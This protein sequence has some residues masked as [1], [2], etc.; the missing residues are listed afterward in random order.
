M[1]SFWPD[2]NA[3]RLRNGERLSASKFSLASS[4]LR[5][6]AKLLLTSTLL[7]TPVL[8]INMPVAHAQVP[9]VTQ[10]NPDAELLLQ[11]DRLIYDND[12]K[13]VTAQ[14]NVQLDYDGYRV[15][16]DQVSYNQTTNKVV[17]SGNVEIVE[18]GGNRI[19]ADQIDLTDDFSEGFVNALRVETTD[20]TRFAAESAERFRDQK[21]VFYH[22]VYTACEACKDKPQKPPL[23]QI[24]AE[25]VILNGVTKTVSYRNARF[26]LFGL[27]I[28]YVPYF[29]HPDGSIKR[30]S[31][32]LTPTVGYEDSVGAWVRQPYF[33]AT[34]DSHDLT[35]AAT[36]FTK[37]GGMLDAKW[38]HQ[39]ENGFY[40]IQVAGIVQQDRTAFS[41][42]PDNAN[43]ERGMI[44]TEGRFTINPKWTFGWK[45]LS[46]TDSNFSRTYKIKNF[47]SYETTNEV[48]LTGLHNR[49]YFNLSA[50]QYLIQNDTLL[51]NGTA[52]QFSSA[53]PIVRPLLDYNY[54]TDDPLAGGQLKL[55]VNVTS[56]ERDTLSF[57]TPSSGDTRTHGIAGDTTRVS[58]DLEWKKSVSAA[59]LNITPLLSLR[60]DWTT[61][62][63]FAASTGTQPTT[64]DYTRFMPTAGLEISYPVLAKVGGSSHIFEPVAQVF[65]R[66]DLDFKGVA[67]NEDAQSL[68]FDATTLFQRD[69]FSGYDRIEGGTRANIGVRYSGQF[70]NGLS[71]D[72]LFG[73]SIHLA[74]LNPYARQDDLTNVGE[75]SGLET[76]RSDFVAALGF[77][78][79]SIYTLNTLGRFDE[80]NFSVR[81]G[82]VQLGVNSELI[83]G[84]SNYTYISAQPDYG[85]E[86][87]RHQVGFSGTLKLTDNWSVAAGAQYDLGRRQF[88]SHSA[89]L[90]YADECFA[91]SLAYSETSPTTSSE[92]NR[93]IGFKMSFRTL[94]EFDGNLDG[95]AFDGLSSQNN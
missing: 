3:V 80:N 64:G 19:F 50:K 18:P 62:N 42:A 25:Q 83:T 14:G 5:P 87:D 67:V 71:V 69:K 39:L 60:G 4:P 1:N 24:K 90:S 63:G 21:T 77:N 8:L 81:R 16:A 48:Y 37:Q 20:N 93:T 34:G 43:E 26:Q 82:E 94:G 66:P 61:T 29:S 51:G 22:G 73:Q 57:V 7:A 30:R 89:G 91:L 33:W 12:N 17:A 31:G 85:F 78:N 40:S 41:T 23:W 86:T 13:K 72:G 52:F 95:T 44:G 15:V 2:P 65:A 49:S 84:T 76:K 92:V 58:A 6:F 54:V 9:G 55:D 46:Q 45:V 38:R 79:G 32:F 88:V 59:G 35:V 75:E 28:A 70:E 36:G 74:G 27:P 53:Q 56:L 10:T 47:S 68:V 11:A